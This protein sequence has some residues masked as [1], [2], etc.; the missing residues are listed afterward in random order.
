MPRTTKLYPRA[1][2]CQC[3]ARSCLAGEFILKDC[4]KQLR[5]GLEIVLRFVRRLRPRHQDDG[6]QQHER[7]RPEVG[8]R[9][10]LPLLRGQDIQQVQGLLHRKDAR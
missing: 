7:R 6:R 2:L 5:V 10:A 8:G 1:E 4:E 3:K 9:L